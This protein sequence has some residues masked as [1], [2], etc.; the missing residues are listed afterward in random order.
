MDVL[1]RVD[2][3]PEIRASIERNVAALRL[4]EDL[5]RWGAGET[6]AKEIVE[7]V[8]QDEYTHDVVMQWDE[9]LALAFDTT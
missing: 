6:P 1:F 3:R 5:I 2:V 9:H 7:I 8:V 4:L